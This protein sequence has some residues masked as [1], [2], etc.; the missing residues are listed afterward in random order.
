MDILRF[1]NI[2]KLV[3]T[4]TILATCILKMISKALHS[5]IFYDL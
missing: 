4:K 1:L 2:L 3:L 5:E